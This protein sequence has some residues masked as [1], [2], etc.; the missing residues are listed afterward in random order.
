MSTLSR[1]TFR[2]QVRHCGGYRYALWSSFGSFILNLATRDFLK[3]RALGHGFLFLFYG[4]NPEL[5]VSPAKPL[6]SGSV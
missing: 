5:A 4:K 3:I 2:L 6:E 1:R